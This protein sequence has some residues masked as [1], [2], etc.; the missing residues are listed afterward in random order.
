MALH[1]FRFS[2]SIY[3]GLTPILVVCRLSL[4]CLTLVFGSA[5]LSICSVILAGISFWV[6]A[7]NGFYFV[8]AMASFIWRS[9]ALS[10][11]IFLQVLLFVIVASFIKLSLFISSILFASRIC[12]L[13]MMYSTGIYGQSRSGG[14]LLGCLFYCFI[15]DSSEFGF[16]FFGRRAAFAGICQYG[17]NY[18]VN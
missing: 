2:L 9:S 7:F 14:S 3:S 16:I 13:V 6:R 18:G 15:E 5:S 8:V 11:I 12:F 17:Y 1:C 10:S 4:Q